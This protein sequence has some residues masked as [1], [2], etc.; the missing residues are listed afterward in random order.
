MASLGMVGKGKRPRDTN[1]LAKWIVDQSTGNLADPNEG[2]NPA[3]V[4][5]GR[6]GGLKGG[7]ARAKTLS[8]KKRK[9]I[10]KKGAAA[11]WRGQELNAMIRES[12]ERANSV[13]QKAREKMTPE[14]RERADKNASA[15]LDH[16]S[17]AAKR[18]R[19]GA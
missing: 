2:K 17:A 10:A 5:L 1:Q 12:A 4:A 8:A 3:A 14:E 13:I 11:R 6:L 18:S 19:R 15:I 7:K 9:S 16:A